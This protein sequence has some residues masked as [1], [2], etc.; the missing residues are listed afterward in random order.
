MDEG[1]GHRYFLQGECCCQ[2]THSPE[3]GGGGDPLLPI[4]PDRDLGTTIKSQ[5]MLVEI[6]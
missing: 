2:N 3:S 1:P 4:E 6:Y 5:Q